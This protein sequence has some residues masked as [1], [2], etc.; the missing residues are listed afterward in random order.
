MRR[1]APRPDG[2]IV[3]EELRIGASRRRLFVLDRVLDGAAIRRVYRWFTDLPVTLSDT[4]RPDTAHV[5]HL[6]HDFESEDWQSH[7]AL[8]ALTAA[9]RGFLRGRR[10]SCGEVYRIYANVNLH[11][12]FQFAHEDGEGWTALAF[13]NSRWDEDWAGELIVYPDGTDTHAYCIA[14]RPGRMVIFD[15]M[16]RH[17]GGSPSKFCLEPRITL[18]IKFGPTDRLAAS[19][20]RKP[21]SRP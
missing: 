4:D 11:G 12:D 6:K 17:R 14:P 15:G 21:A 10:I 7:P 2:Q 13:V 19:R 3:Y 18:A 20:A 8:K 5:R 9:A 1:L 16:I